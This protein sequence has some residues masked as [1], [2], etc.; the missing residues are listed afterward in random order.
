MKKLTL[1]IAIVLSWIMITSCSN[2]EKIVKNEKGKVIFKP[3]YDTVIAKRTLR[4][5]D[6]FY[7]ND[8]S[9]SYKLIRLHRG[10]TVSV[11]H[12]NKK[13]SYVKYN[14]VKGTIST[15]TIDPE[16]ADIKQKPADGIKYKG[17]FVSKYE[18]ADGLYKKQ[19]YKKGNTYY[20]YI[21]G[22]LD[23]KYTTNY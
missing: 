17:E 11:F 3:T 22:K 23:S 10:D 13:S 16:K 21:N 2:E 15:L 6:V 20:T 7:V 4:Y 18:S 9:V 1:I 5:N 14:N 12:W 8:T 19:V